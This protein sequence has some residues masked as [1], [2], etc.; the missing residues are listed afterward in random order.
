MSITW[1]TK[2]SAISFYTALYNKLVNVSAKWAKKETFLFWHVLKFGSEIFKKNWGKVC[3]SNVDNFD[4]VE[5]KSL[6]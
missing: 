6:W 5:F 1:P 2:P 3:Y 4:K